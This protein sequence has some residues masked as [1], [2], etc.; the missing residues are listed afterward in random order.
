MI[1]EHDSLAN[2]E[3]ENFNTSHNDS[4]P[5][6]SPRKK[7]GYDRFYYQ[8]DLRRDGSKSPGSN[9]QIRDPKQKGYNQFIQ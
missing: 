7:M 4:F 5:E 1:S 3:E 8:T 9:K 2:L 6:I